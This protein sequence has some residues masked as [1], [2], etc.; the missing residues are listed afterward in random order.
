MGKIIIGL[1]GEKLAGKDT[2][3]EYLVKK[4][5]A[6]HI[7]F[8]HLLDEILEILDLPKTRRNEIDLGLGLRKIFGMEVLYRALK[9]RALTAD[10]A[11]II[12]NGIRMDEFERMISDDLGAKMIYITAPLELRYQ[13]YQNRHEKVDDGKLSFEE[14]GRQD[15]EEETERGIPGLGVRAAYRIDNT[16]TVEELYEKVENVIKK[17]FI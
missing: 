2:V 16:G 3:A 6:F 14:F 17:I 11:M 12:I 15:R 1:V 5:G 13:R 4:Q 10:A 9:K 7:K 8:S